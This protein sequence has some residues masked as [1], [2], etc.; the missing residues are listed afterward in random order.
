MW[1]QLRAGHTATFEPRRTTASS[2]YLHETSSRRITSCGPPVVGKLFESRMIPQTR[3]H[4]GRPAR[5]AR[6]TSLLEQLAE[7]DSQTHH[8]GR[9][10]GG[11]KIVRTTDDPATTPARRTPCAASAS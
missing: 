2:K 5:R 9:P 11:G 8:L 7:D 3:R 1:S 6:P 4:A 10:A